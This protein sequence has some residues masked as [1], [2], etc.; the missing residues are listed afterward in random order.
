MLSLS[1]G[2]LCCWLVPIISP[3]HVLHT[4]AW[5]TVSQLWKKKNMSAEVIAINLFLFSSRCFFAL[6]FYSRPTF[7]S[8]RPWL[9]RRAETARPLLSSFKPLTCA[10]SV[11]CGILHTRKVVNAPVGSVRRCSSRRFG[12]RETVF[13]TTLLHV[14]WVLCSEGT[15]AGSQ[16]PRNAWILCMHFVRLCGE[17]RCFWCLVLLWLDS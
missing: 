10:T 11:L 2:V 8:Q 5:I 13:S 1:P 3:L 17:K 16:R 9:C 14:G 12:S 7:Y 15:L 6:L 4:S